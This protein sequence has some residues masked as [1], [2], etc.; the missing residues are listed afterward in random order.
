MKG[1]VW[2]GKKEGGFSLPELMAAFA[3]I[4]ILAAVAVPAV[5]NWLPGYRLK[6]AA[7]NLYSNMQQARLTAVRSN[8]AC[9]VVFNAATDQY[10]ICTD[11]GADG[12]WSTT[13]DNTVLKTIDLS[14]LPGNIQYGHASATDPLPVGGGGAWGNEIT[15]ASAGN[16]VAV[17]SVRGLLD[18]PSGY[19]YIQNNEGSTYGIGAFTSG[20]MTLQKCNVASPGTWD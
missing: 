12:N 4:A 11:N 20:V 15:F 8:A 3:I 1:R 5:I 16:D 10:F 7:R 17:F 2:E 14:E 19:V 9:A 13:G 18:P 6:K